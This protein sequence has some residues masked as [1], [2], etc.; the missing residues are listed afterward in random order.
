MSVYVC[1]S[2]PKYQ[3]QSSLVSLIIRLRRLLQQTNAIRRHQAAAER[4]SHVHGSRVGLASVDSV[5]DYSSL[6]P[7]SSVI[8]NN[9]ANSFGANLL[10]SVRVITT[11]RPE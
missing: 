6:L 7:N 5:L 1:S 4:L 8:R 2:L 9:A 3:T 10:V 11:A